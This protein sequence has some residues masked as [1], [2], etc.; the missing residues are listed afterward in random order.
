MMGITHVYI[1]TMSAVLLTELE[2]PRSCLAALIGGSLGGILC[3]MDRDPGNRRSDAGQARRIACSITLACF[4]FDLLFDLGLTRSMMQGKAAHRLAGLA[5]FLALSL[6]TMTQPHRGGSH[7]AAFALLSGLC[8]EL[9][10]VGFGRPLL[11]GMSSHLALDLLNR[12]PLRLLYPLP[13]RWCL[14]LCRADGRTDR[15][16]R[17]VGMFGTVLGLGIAIG[18]T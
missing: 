9:I 10:C 17:R 16:L 8:A 4:A 13:G 11:I 7:S 5:G 18:N 14:G 6:F 1:G 15:L 12:R 3:D 2:S